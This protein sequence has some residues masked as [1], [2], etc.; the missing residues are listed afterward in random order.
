MKSW[1]KKISLVLLML[2]FCIIWF[3]PFHI[4]WYREMPYCK[5]RFQVFSYQ[6]HDYGST[7]WQDRLLR[8]RPNKYDAYYFHKKVGGI[9][10]YFG[11]EPLPIKLTKDCCGWDKVES[12]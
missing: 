2:S 6:T 7:D 1:I 10:T 12:K 5:F 9:K 8:M 11:L 3:V 4:G